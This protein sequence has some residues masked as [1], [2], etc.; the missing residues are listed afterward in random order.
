MFNRICH[1]ILD[2]LGIAVAE[3]TLHDLVWQS[4]HHTE[5][6][7]ADAGF[8]A[9]ARLLIDLHTSMVI[10]LDGINWTGLATRGLLALGANNR[11][12]QTQRMFL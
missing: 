7:C 11:R 4:H 3:L 6:A 9:N 2:A 5:G 1:T 10:L 8:T 12:T